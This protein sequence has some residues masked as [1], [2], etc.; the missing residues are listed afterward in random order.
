MRPA[1]DKWTDAARRRP[2]RRA[3]PVGGPPC[4]H[5]ADAARLVPRRTQLVCLTRKTWL[6]AER[7]RTATRIRSLRKGSPKG[8]RRVIDHLADT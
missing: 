1:K 7:Q 8:E 4:A 2:R 6:T 5:P 3:R